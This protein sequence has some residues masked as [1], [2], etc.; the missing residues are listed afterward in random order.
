MICEQ[1]GISGG[2]DAFAISIAAWESGKLHHSD[3]NL[4]TRISSGG[5]GNHDSVSHLKSRAGRLREYGG[6]LYEADSTSYLDNR[7]GDL[8]QIPTSPA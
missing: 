5:D 2:P 6:R 3:R 4:F 7:T 8:D 1:I